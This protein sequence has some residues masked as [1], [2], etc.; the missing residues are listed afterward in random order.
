MINA[1]QLK[2]GMIIVRDGELFR[3]MRVDH[4][5][6]GKGNAFIR[7]QL[8][9]LRLGN[10]AEARLNSQEKVEKA[11]LDTRE[12]EYL[13]NDGENYFFMDTA[14][15]EQIQMAKETLGDG[16]NYML[17]NHKIQVDMYEGN[18]VGV[19]FSKTVELKV[20]EAEPSVKR[21]TASAQTKNAKLETGMNIR[22]PSFVK[23]D[24]VIRVDTETGEYVERV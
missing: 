24:D 19:E 9:N 1:A 13:Y 21:A 2:R 11:I 5:T 22:V 15:Y 23:T 6:P 17:P 7:A 12:M 14:N 18:P 3:I 10:Q 4:I 20:V 16:V 8:R